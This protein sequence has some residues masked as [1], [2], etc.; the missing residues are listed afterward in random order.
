[1]FPVVVPLVPSPVLVLRALLW[2]F[3]SCVFLCFVSFCVPLA[4]LVSRYLAVLLVLPRWR[5]DRHIKCRR[6]AQNA[7]WSN[8]TLEIIDHI[9]K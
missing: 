5:H 1:M 4:F 8:C 7:L 6:C 2:L 9:L 3:V